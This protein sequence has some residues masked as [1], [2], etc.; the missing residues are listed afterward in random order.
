MSTKK[1]AESSDAAGQAVSR[2]KGKQIE[3]MSVGE[4]K[5]HF[6]IPNGVSVQLL[7]GGPVSTHKVDD[8]SIYFTK[9]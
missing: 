6:V 2:G 3:L 1:V 9:E 4:F 7:E 8:G 5:Q